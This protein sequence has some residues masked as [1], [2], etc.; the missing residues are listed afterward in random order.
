MPQAPSPP[1][2]PSDANLLRDCLY[3]QKYSAVRAFA[4]RHNLNNFIQGH[5]EVYNGTWRQKAINFQRLS[6]EG[7]HE[8]RIA[9]F[10][11]LR[12]KSIIYATDDN[13]FYAEVV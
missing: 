3:W 8:A 10:E 12:R 4:A 1:L 6:A 9:L 2:Y 11:I 5:P 7:A 13:G